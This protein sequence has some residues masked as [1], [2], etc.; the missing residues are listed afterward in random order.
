MKKLK[1]S[2]LFYLLFIVIAFA[3]FR[4][5]LVSASIVY[6]SVETTVSNFDNSYWT[7][8]ANIYGFSDNAYTSSTDFQASYYYYI[9]LQQTVGANHF[10]DIDIPNSSTIDSILYS[11]RAYSTATSTF[12]LG[13]RFCAGVD[14]NYCTDTEKVALTSSPA[15]YIWDFDSNDDF[16]HNVTGASVN[17]YDIDHSPR[18][19]VSGDT[20]AHGPVYIDSIVM[21]VFYH[22]NTADTSDG[23]RFVSSNI[24]NG[25][26]TTT[27][28][29]LVTTGADLNISYYYNSDDDNATSTKYT[30]IKVT[31]HDNFT[32]KNEYLYKNIGL[33]DVVTAVQFPNFCTDAL[34]ANGD[35]FTMDYQFVNDDE[36][37]RS[38]I[39]SWGQTTYYFTYNART[40]IG[41]GTS[42]NPFSTSTNPFGGNGTSTLNLLQQILAISPTAQNV[43]VYCNLLNIT[44]FNPLGCVYYL[45]VPE[46]D[47]VVVFF[48]VF[49]NTVLARMPFIGSFWTTSATSL[50]SISAT[51]P[52]GFPGAGSTL[53]LGLTGKIMGTGS[54][55]STATSTGNGQTLYQ[56]TSSYWNT[57]VY[58]C[59]GFY[60]L[61]RLL[62]AHLFSKFIRRK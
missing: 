18:I 14:A 12:D 35:T 39:T 55:L 6:K 7:N 24:V 13:L 53:S 36:T 21:T 15:Y 2:S 61:S 26:S 47:D 8:D 28:P 34:C 11:V 43:L 58:L 1:A 23:T 54:I 29:N 19:Q 30:K 31:I 59:L 51:I 49:K 22:Y 25:Y 10:A 42:T 41:F 44:H 38:I 3:C 56:L 57:F 16:F 45:I 60:F 32:N 37:V 27:I 62:S 4:V 33:K 9:S 52:S 17:A 40:D 48:D 50:P 46:S 5:E 20:T